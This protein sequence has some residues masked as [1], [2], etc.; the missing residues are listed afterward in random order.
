MGIL[1]VYDI[2]S[3]KS[4]DSIRNW[5]RNIEEHASSDVE[6]MLIGNKCDMSEKRQVSK[7]RAEKLAIE[8]GMKF[9]ET[10]AKQNENIENAFFTLA[11][12][13]KE[14]TEKRLVSFVL[15]YFY[16]LKL[17][18]LRLRAHH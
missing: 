4:F 6:R 14:K 15:A 1:L 2:T 11:R 3:E 18:R 7:E 9:M 8:Y 13:I 10:S 12:D 5:I 16:W 17:N